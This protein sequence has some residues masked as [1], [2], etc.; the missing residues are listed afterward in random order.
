MTKPNGDPLQVTSNEVSTSRFA[1][2]GEFRIWV[3]GDIL[4]YDATGPFNLEALHALAAAR[5]KISRQWKPGRRVAAIVHWH[6]SALMSPE[7]FAAYGEGLAKFH[8]RANM[9]V[10]LAWVASADVEGMS[11]MI[12]KFEHLFT[13]RKT[14]F[15]LFE[16]LEPARAWVD[17]CLASAQ[18]DPAD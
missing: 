3:Q 18:A 13:Q 8:E 17:A 5:A 10:A 7:A 2:H 4:F 15:R 6:G 9:P 12:A 14:N 1:P 16:S 11:L